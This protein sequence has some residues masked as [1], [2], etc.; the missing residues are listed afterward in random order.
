MS[1]RYK[2][3]SSTDAN[4]PNFIYYSGALG[5]FY[6]IRMWTLALI[7]CREKSHHFKLRYE[8]SATLALSMENLRISL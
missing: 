7:M 6:Q 3:T 1:A 5:V 8:T 4:Y 2:A